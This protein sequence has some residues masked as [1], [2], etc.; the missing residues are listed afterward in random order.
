MTYHDSLEVT[1]PR[2]AYPLQKKP[3]KRSLRG[4]CCSCG[5]L[6]PLL[7]FL[8]LGLAYFLI[9]WR[10]NI[11]VLGIDA[12]QPGSFVGRTDTMILVTTD[13]FKPYIGMLS[14]PRDL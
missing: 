3:E 7:G 1:R 5:C 12:R 13:P 10:S 9:P 11:L 6:I 2:R 8:L 4:F 14:I